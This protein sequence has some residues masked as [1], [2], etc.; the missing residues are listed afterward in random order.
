MPDEAMASQT[1]PQG[2]RL[3]LRDPETAYRAPVAGPL[4]SAIAAEIR[5]KRAARDWD[6]RELG[7]RLGW[8]QKVISNIERGK[9]QLTLDELSRICAVFG[10]GLADLVADADADAVR[11]LR[12]R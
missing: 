3:D 2:V 6:Q 8:T 11:P 1:G 7:R 12:L 9:R 5:G 10:I 4:G